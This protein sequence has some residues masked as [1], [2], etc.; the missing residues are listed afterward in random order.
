MQATAYANLAARMG[1]EIGVSS[2]IE[3]DQARIDRFAEV[4]GDDGFIH[5]D[6]GRAAATP[7]GGTIAHGLLL[8]SLTGAMGKEVLPAITDRAYLLNYGYD[9]VRLLSPVPVGSCVRGRYR[10]EEAIDRSPRERLLRFGL[11]VER[12]GGERPALVADWLLMVV[13]R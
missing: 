7:F 6:P 10:L 12:Q 2:W 13:L 1:D 9:R 11:T 8:L 5:V 3:I 4:S